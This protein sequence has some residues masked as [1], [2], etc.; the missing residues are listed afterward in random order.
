MNVSKDVNEASK[1]DKKFE[2]LSDQCHLF[3]DVVNDII[4]LY[5]IENGWLFEIFAMLLSEL[6]A[7]YKVMAELRDVAMSDLESEDDEE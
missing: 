3:K 1:L 2:S 5:M 4:S 7:S 6:A